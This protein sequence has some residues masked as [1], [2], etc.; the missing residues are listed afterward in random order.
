MTNVQF[1]S[2]A[3]HAAIVILLAV[4]GF[5]WNHE[6]Q[7]VFSLQSEVA[8]LEVQNAILRTEKEASEAKA[9]EAQKQIENLRNKL[10]PFR[11]RRNWHVAVPLVKGATATAESLPPEPEAVAKK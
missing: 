11:D 3:P 4:A 6:R 2:I 1:R 9:H 7:Q 5:A 10:D 8:E